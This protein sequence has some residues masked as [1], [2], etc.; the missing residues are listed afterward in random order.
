MREREGREKGGR[1]S[2]CLVTAG[3]D[4]RGDEDMIAILP[5]SKILLRFTFDGI[6]RTI[7]CPWHWGG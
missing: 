5:S 2:I 3:Q 6:R 4:H 1:E 7:R